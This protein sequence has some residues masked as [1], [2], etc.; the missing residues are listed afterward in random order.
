[1][2]S[3]CI[4]NQ[5]WRRFPGIC[6][7]RILVWYWSLHLQL[8]VF[9]VFDVSKIFL[10]IFDFQDRQDHLVRM[11]VHNSI[12]CGISPSMRRPGQSSST[13]PLMNLAR[14]FGHGE[15][16]TVPLKVLGVKHTVRDVASYNQHMASE[17][18]VTQRCS[19]GY[20]AITYRLL[21]IV[22]VGA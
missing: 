3:N 10:L 7:Q 20:E 9:D 22:F 8:H 19:G 21:S 11:L 17:I 15:L 1:M 18:P 5:V 13:L 16:G 4:G 6:I 2:R 12:S 14:D